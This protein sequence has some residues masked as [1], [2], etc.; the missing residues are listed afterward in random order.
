VIIAIIVLIL[1]PFGSGK[2]GNYNRALA[3]TKTIARTITASGVVTVINQKS[4]TT[5]S[6][7]VTQSRSFYIVGL[8]AGSQT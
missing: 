7:A 3:T 8:V 1:L 5:A 2:T 6:G 4:D